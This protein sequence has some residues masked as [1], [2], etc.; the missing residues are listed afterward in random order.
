MS[1]RHPHTH[2]LLFSAQ[3]AHP[4]ARRCDVNKTVLGIIRTEAEA[5]T[6]CLCLRGDHRSVRSN[7]PGPVETAPH[8]QGWV[9]FKSSVSDSGSHTYPAV[10]FPESISFIIRPSFFFPAPNNCIHFICAYS[11]ILNLSPQSINI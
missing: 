5:P 8:G 6:S 2:C 1:L 11:N 7:P 3:Q 4:E 9:S 10:C